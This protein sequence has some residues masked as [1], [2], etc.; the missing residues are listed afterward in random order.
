MQAHAADQWQSWVL[1]CFHIQELGQCPPCL[2]HLLGPGVGVMGVVGTRCAE[3]LPD[4]CVPSQEEIRHPPKVQEQMDYVL[5]VLKLKDIFTLTGFAPNSH[6][7]T[8]HTLN[9]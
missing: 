6:F 7:A 3:H 9:R 8:F 5:F 1:A 4:C 2:G